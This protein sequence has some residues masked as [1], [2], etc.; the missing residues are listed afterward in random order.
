MLT[1]FFGAAFVVMAIFHWFGHPLFL[2]GKYRQSDS[3]REYQRGLVLPYLIVGIGFILL[4]RVYPT[5]EAQN[6]LDFGVGILVICVVAM[7]LIW[8][9]RRKCGL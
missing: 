4:W 5:A 7:A 8:K 2:A 3:R 6:S 1:F 9:N